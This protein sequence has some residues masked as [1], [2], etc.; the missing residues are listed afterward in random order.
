MYI[1]NNVYYNKKCTIMTYAAELYL[2]LTIFLTF[3]KYI[4]V[5]VLLSYI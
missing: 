1:I 4:Y 5:H 2:L 3:S